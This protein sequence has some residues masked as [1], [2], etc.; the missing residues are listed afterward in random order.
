M[1]ASSDRD[2]ILSARRGEMQAFGELIR[3]Y[4][5]TV[6]NVCYRILGERREAEDLTQETFLRIHSRLGLVDLE[7]PFGPWLKRVAAN[8]CFN[9]LELLPPSQPEIDDERDQDDPAHRPE[10][11]IEQHQQAQSLRAA[12]ADLPPRY[13]AIIELR[14]F[15]E[16]SYEE[17]AANL[18]IPIS[19]VKSDLFRARK[20]LAGKLKNEPSLR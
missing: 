13:R 12:L 20:L 6:F 7:R 5:L 18:A 1:D 8:L 3:R 2:L 4:Q 17:I 9:R 19:A 15:Q 14:H 16:L 11:A 10:A